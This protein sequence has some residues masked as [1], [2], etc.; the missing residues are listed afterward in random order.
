[1]LNDHLKNGL[2]TQWFS[3]TFTIITNNELYKWGIIVYMKQILPKK[4]SEIRMVENTPR[5]RFLK[6][7]VSSEQYD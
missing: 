5:T 4:I 7:A 6:C 1:M 2:L 3:I